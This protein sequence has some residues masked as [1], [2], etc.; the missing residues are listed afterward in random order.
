M[1]IITIKSKD[2]VSSVE[3]MEKIVEEPPEKSVEV[4]K[5]K[6]VTRQQRKRASVNQTEKPASVSPKKPRSKKKNKDKKSKQK[7]KTKSGLDK[8]HKKKK[9]KAKPKTKKSKQPKKTTIIPALLLHD[10][11][12]SLTSLKRICR[13]SGVGSMELN[14]L[15]Y[16]RTIIEKHVDQLCKN[17]LLYMKSSADK[18]YLERGRKT[19]SKDDVKN[20]LKVMNTPFYG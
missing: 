19:I 2:G 3:P 18:S 9:K 12:V 13:R 10:K 11:H 17:A 15:S 1:V 7:K 20:A 5:D 4:P 16:L 14:L 6:R 8:I